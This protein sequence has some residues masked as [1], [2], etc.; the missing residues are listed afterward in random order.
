MQTKPNLIDDIGQAIG[1]A[2]TMRLLAIYGGT[3]LY[4]PETIDADHLIAK[5]IGLE[6]AR[7]LS[8]TFARE[9]LDLPDA[10]DFTRLQRIRR[11]AGLLRAATPPRDIAMLVGLST[12]QV[13]RYRTEAEQMGLIPMVFGAQEAGR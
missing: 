8:A 1:A 10:D 13:C 9:Q 2:S 3:K 4:V 7:A 12:K 6:S 11:V 5:A